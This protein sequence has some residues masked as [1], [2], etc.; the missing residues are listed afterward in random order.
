MKDLVESSTVCV[1]LILNTCTLMLLFFCCSFVVVFCFLFLIV[2]FVCFV[3]VRM[4]C[5][6]A[7]QF[8][9]ANSNENK[10]QTILLS[11][12]IHGRSADDVG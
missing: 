5:L 8:Y 2:L 6:F 4:H 11:P 9:T 1:V 12:V 3:N 7:N 10:H